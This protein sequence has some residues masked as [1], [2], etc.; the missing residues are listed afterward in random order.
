MVFPQ[1]IGEGG[2]PSYRRQAS[3]D[4]E[5]G[6]GGVP[7]YTH[8]GTSSSALWRG[9]P[10]RTVDAILRL[11]ERAEYLIIVEAV[12]RGTYIP[13]LE[14]DIDL[15]KRTQ[16]RRNVRKSEYPIEARASILE[17]V[18]PLPPKV[19]VDGI[20]SI[21][22]IG[23]NEYAEAL[24]RGL[25]THGPASSITTLTRLA[26][27][28]LAA[29]VDALIDTRSLID[30]FT[31]QGARLGMAITSYSSNEDSSTGPNAYFTIE[32]EQVQTGS[33]MIR[34]GTLDQ[35][36][37]PGGAQPAPLPAAA[38]NSGAAQ[39]RAATSTHGTVQTREADVAVEEIFV[40]TGFW[41]RPVNELFITGSLPD[42]AN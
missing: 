16:W 1:E 14:D 40:E 13:Q 39:D 20:A 31:R 22:R 23:T 3:D 7:A 19:T 33:V 17:H 29:T 6:E 26:P 41:Q 25:V 10:R 37:G 4:R 12:R 38:T 28:Y 2:V 15:V 24:D 11:R 5:I 36:E 9:A 35:A 27:F 18:R 34:T 42:G 8:Q 30:V 21:N 32:L